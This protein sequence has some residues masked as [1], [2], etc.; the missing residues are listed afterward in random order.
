MASLT[1]LKFNVW[2]KDTHRYIMQAILDYMGIISLEAEDISIHL[3]LTFFLIQWSRWGAVHEEIFDFCFL[4]GFWS[5][6]QTKEVL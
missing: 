2:Q 5:S 6:V 1:N 3:L 4:G